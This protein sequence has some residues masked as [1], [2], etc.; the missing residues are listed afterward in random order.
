VAQAIVSVR[1]GALARH[2]GAILDARAAEAGML[3]SPRPDAVRR[4]NRAQAPE[5]G[6]P[7]EGSR[8]MMKAS[9][10]ANL[11]MVLAACSSLLQFYG[12]V[13]GIG[14]PAPSLSGAESATRMKL[15]TTTWALGL[16]LLPIALGLAGF[17]YAGAKKR[18]MAAW[19]LGALPLL[20]LTLLELIRG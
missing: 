17:S 11:A 5:P 10:A 1:I 9:T 20:G 13:T 4:E 2:G 3:R 16:G 7:A 12:V 14:D 19:L 18:A 6:R 15:S 8:G